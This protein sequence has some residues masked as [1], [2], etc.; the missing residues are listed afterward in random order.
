M[1]SSSTSTG[2]PSEGGIGLHKY[3]GSKTK[4]EGVLSQDSTKK[5]SSKKQDIRLLIF[6]EKR[7]KEEAGI[8]DSDSTMLTGNAIKKRVSE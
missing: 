6:K 8:E 7:T 1:R 3:F 5:D 2:K 4:A